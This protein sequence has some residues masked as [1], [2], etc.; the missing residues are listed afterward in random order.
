LGIR[1]LISFTGSSLY[2]ASLHV[3]RGMAAGLGFHLW[4]RNSY[5]LGSLEPGYSDLDLSLL[6]RGRGSRT[7]LFF[8]IYG[9]FKRVWPLL[10]EVNFY[11][12]ESL[13]LIEGQHNSFE[14][15]RDPLLLKRL[16]KTLKPEPIEAAIFLLRQ[17]EKDLHNLKKRPQKRLKK[18]RSHYQ[19]I[20]SSFPESDLSGAL[21]LDAGRIT[22]SVAGAVVNLIQVQFYS[23]WNPVRLR[24]MNQRLFFYI[25]LLEG[26]IDLSAAKNFWTLEK[27]FIA[28]SPHKVVD[29][30]TFRVKFSDDQLRFLVGQMKWEICGVLSQLESEFSRSEAADYFGRLKASAEQLLIF[31]NGPQVHDLLLLFERALGLIH[32]Q[33]TNKQILQ[34]TECTVYL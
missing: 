24:E 22:E 15:R 30:E 31:N 19:E 21:V 25:Q 16:N 4:P 23:N 1:E 27:W 32:P 5:V 12:P 34:K 17:L 14:L 28:W 10:G 7:E 20:K 6:Q 13:S 2:S 9:F 29:A 18:W 3:V 8:S 26:G 11:T 33:L